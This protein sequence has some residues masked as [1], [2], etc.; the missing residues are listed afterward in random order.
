MSLLISSL[1]LPLKLLVSL[2]GSKKK[3]LKKTERKQ[4]QLAHVRNFD[5]TRL[6]NR[7]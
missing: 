7:S 6:N 3:R 2:V 5:P 1:K 4:K